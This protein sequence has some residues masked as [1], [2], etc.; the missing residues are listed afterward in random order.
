MSLYCGIDLHSN[1]S[2]LV[3]LYAD[4]V[5][6]FRRRLAND[7]S[8]ILPALSRFR[9]DL[10][11]IAIESTYNGYWLIDGLQ[12]DGHVVRLANPSAIKQYAGAKH[13]ADPE[14]AEQLATLLRLNALPEG[15]IY[16]AADRGIRDL[17]R[18]RLRLV[19]QRTSHILSLET[20][21][22]RHTGRHPRWAALHKL[23]ID[24]LVALAP[25]SWVQESMAVS[26]AMIGLLG[27]QINRI[28]VKVLRE[29]R[30]RPVFRALSTVPGIGR[31]LGPTIVL[32]A[33]PIERFA[34]VGNYSSYCRCVSSGRYSNGKRKGRGNAKNGNKYLAWAY[35]EAAAIARGRYPEA[36][37][38]YQ[39]KLNQTS[40]VV[41]SKAL[42]HKL[43]RSS[44][45]VMRDGTPFDPKRCFG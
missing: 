22:A 20:N 12:A 33:G 41:A 43:A 29:I 6:K 24:E 5:V 13:S 40:A 30:P 32:E 16:P 11:G 42:A 19:Q 26:W 23:S 2:Y 7:L 18:K 8:V 36:Q 34:G 37:R 28:Q 9:S 17:L 15:Y 1:N 44:Y 31:V 3:V 14:D 45:Y 4:G 27:E 21:V 25:D 38:F 10:E 39:R 35:M